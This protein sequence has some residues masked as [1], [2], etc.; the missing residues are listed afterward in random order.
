MSYSRT[1]ALVAFLLAVLQPAAA[2]LSEKALLSTVGA[3]AYSDCTQIF[4]RECCVCSRVVFYLLATGEPEAA[5]AKPYAML[6][7]GVAR[8]EPWDDEYSKILQYARALLP[9]GYAPTVP[10]EDGFRNELLL[11]GRRAQTN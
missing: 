8:G 1:V 11:V 7:D 4:R 2:V 3:C 5:T 10:S 9:Y 6:R